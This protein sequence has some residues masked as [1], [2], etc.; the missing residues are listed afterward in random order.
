MAAQKLLKSL[1]LLSHFYSL[2]W[3]LSACLATLYN[4]SLLPSP[5][6]KVKV[7]QDY[8]FL[9]YSDYFLSYSLSY[10]HYDVGAK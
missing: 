9:E 1:L 4:L 8:L 7:Y 3:C 10:C 6:P 2:K 5:K